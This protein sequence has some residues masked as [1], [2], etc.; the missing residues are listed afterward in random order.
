MPTS[1]ACVSNGQP[2]FDCPAPSA[3]LWQSTGKKCV[4]ARPD[5]DSTWAKHNW[6][7]PADYW[8]RCDMTVVPTGGSADGAPDA[9]QGGFDSWEEPGSYDCTKVSGETHA[10]NRASAGYNGYLN[11]SNWC[12]TKGCYV[13]PCTCNKNDISGSSWFA[14]RTGV[15][16]GGRLLFSY[17]QCGGTNTFNEASCPSTMTQTQCEAEA[18]CKWVAADVPA[19]GFGAPG[20]QPQAFAAVVAAAILQAMS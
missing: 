7:Y 18:N 2:T 15:A 20:A 4:H 14:S 5:I 19:T 16:G 17:A 8:S 13:D 1:C 12:V 9:H 11:S 3:T 6:S 10:W